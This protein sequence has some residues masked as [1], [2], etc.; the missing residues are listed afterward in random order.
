MLAQE[1]IMAFVHG[2]EL[3]GGVGELP[4]AGFVTVTVA[5]EDVELARGIVEAFDTSNREADAKDENRWDPSDSL[6]DWKS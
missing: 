1:G 6:L 4:A 5:D 3:Q 2:A